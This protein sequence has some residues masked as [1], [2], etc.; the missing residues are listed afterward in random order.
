MRTRGSVV[1]AAR[2]AKA[3]ARH[4]CLEVTCAGCGLIVHT[5]TVHEAAKSPAT[6]EALARQS[7]RKHTEATGCTGEPTGE[8]RVPA[9]RDGRCSGQAV[10]LLPHVVRPTVPEHVPN[11]RCDLDVVAQVFEV[12]PVTE[13]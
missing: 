9:R 4:T 7:L 6:T 5:C 10:A 8:G 12:L 13:P 2:E 11:C 3:K 1:P